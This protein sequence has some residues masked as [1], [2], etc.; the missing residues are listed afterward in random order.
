M[1][2]NLTYVDSDGS[3]K[4]PVVL[5][6][7]ILGSLDRF[8]AYYLE[9]TKGNLP[10]WMNPTQVIV[11]PINS[12]YQGD[13]AKEIYDYL[14]KNKIRV[15]LDDRQEKLNYRLREAQ[16]SKI[17]YTIILGDKEKE[18]NTISYRL[19]SKTETNTLSKKDF[20]KLLEEEIKSKSLTNK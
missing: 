20:L 12:N 9:E 10:L 17:P 13:Y 5:H 4:T 3:K 15:K 7:A 19:Y 2:F 16:I 6:R 11:L 8:I 1:K 18:D 14:K